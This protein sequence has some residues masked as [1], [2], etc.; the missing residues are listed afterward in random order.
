MRKVGETSVNV[1]VAVHQDELPTEFMQD[2]IAVEVPVALVY[3][4]ISH[5]VMMATPDNLEDFA[6]G[7]SLTEDIIGDADEVSHIHVQ[8]SGNGINVRLMISDERFDALRERRRSLVGR[9]GCGLCGVESLKQ[10]IRPV[11]TV[12][13]ID[14]SDEAI[15]YAINSLKQHQALAGLTGATHAAAWCDLQGHIQFVREDVGRHN[16]LDKL[17]GA[18][19]K[20]GLLVSEG[21]AL[22]SSR[23]SY[24]MVQKSASA[25]FGCLVAVSAP[26][27]LAIEQAE[28]VGMKLV[29][30]ARNGRHV[31]YV[32]PKNTIENNTLRQAM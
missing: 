2:D 27:S 22:V 3:N 14:V 25:G 18:H 5:A 17:I 28:N 20:T 11:D 13:G 24:E 19:V 1:S 21:F 4:S 12:V 15:Q 6:L 10:A 31:V 8:S 32:E 7:F 26:T 16:A 23:A 30:F 29:G 9:T